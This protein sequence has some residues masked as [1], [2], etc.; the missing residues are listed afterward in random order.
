[1]TDQ[2]VTDLA[3]EIADSTAMSDIELACPTVGG[4]A[5]VGWLYDVSNPEEIDA[6]FIAQGLRYLDARGILI[7]QSSNPHIISFKKD[8]S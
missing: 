7:R 4:D 1:M 8:R 5:K 3:I 2:T 6:P